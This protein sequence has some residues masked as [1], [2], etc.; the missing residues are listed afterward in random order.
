MNLKIFNDLL[1]E[2]NPARMTST[3]GIFQNVLFDVFKNFSFLFMVNSLCHWF[4]PDYFT[5]NQYGVVS[6]SQ[7][8]SLG[9][10]VS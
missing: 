2:I 3:I 1:R 10:F 9:C 8:E 6:N 5:L 4:F 7:T